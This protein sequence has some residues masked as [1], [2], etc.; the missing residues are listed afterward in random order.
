MASITHVLRRIK[1]D[2]PDL[3]SPT[4][5]EQICREAGYTWR[6]RQ[7]GPAAT[8]HYFIL[9]IL[10][11]NAAC[12]HVPRIAGM[13]FTPSAYCQARMRLPLEVI[14]TLVARI[15]RALQETINKTGLWRGHRV[16][17]C[18]GSGFS[19]SDTPAL[20]A[21]FGQPGGQKKGCG[22]P[23][24]HLLVAFEAGGGL[25]LELVASALR[26]HDLAQVNKI[27]PQLRAGDVLVADRGFCSFAHLVLILRHEMHACVRMHQR[28]IV[29]FEPHRPQAVSQHAKGRPRS[30]W[31]RR[32][33]HG[34]QVVEW[35]KPQR[36]PVWMS[37]E[38]FAALPASL[39]VRELRYQI[40]TP[41]FRTR[42]VT[43]ATTLLDARKYPA[44]ALAE[45]YHTRW[46]VETNFRHLKT[47]MGMDILH[48]K[49]VE[50]V[51]KEL[52]M[53]ALVYNL[54]RRLMLEAARRQR[55]EPD[56]ISFVDAL[57][58]LAHAPP[59]QSL[60]TLVLN[61]L[62][63]GRVEPRVIKRRLKEYPLMKKT[64]HQLRQTLLE[65][66]LVA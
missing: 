36:R 43:L 33:G 54:V 62:R 26:T 5:I 20:Q 66:R 12:S 56:R 3:L 28:Q 57:R 14:T 11:G 6:N 51:L 27:H 25:L 1:S 13:T 63:L 46:Q 32:L 44:E 65:G 2:L 48:C 41:G 10:F 4:F 16:V 50:G 45:L 37:A 47:T 19:M 15:G 39:Q 55:V 64:R 21:H 9:Q 7:L 29:D 34:D 24:A 53:F 40:R 17:W 58:W 18:D 35:I 30:R 22:F 42:E 23:V 60:P 52:W 31:L 38:D 49:T 61:P 59:D 8:I